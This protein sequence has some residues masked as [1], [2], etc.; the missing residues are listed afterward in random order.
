MSA[1]KQKIID[2]SMDDHSKQMLLPA[3]DAVNYLEAWSELSSY[4]PPNDK[5]FSW[6]ED[7]IV[8][9]VRNEICKRDDSHS[10]GSMAWTMRAIEYIAKKG[11]DSYL[12]LV[13]A[14]N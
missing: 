7:S 11:V 13:G 1:I 9:R 5:G 3:I 4:S 6:S 12:Q 8:K 2:S 10:G 14:H